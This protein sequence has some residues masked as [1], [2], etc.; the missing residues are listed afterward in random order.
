MALGWGIA[1]L[2]AIT[3]I[4]L[5]VRIF[6]KTAYKIIM[7]IWFILFLGMIVFGIL[8]YSDAK[9]FSQGFSENKSLFLLEAEEEILAGF[10]T[11]KEDSEIV[12]GVEDINSKY[13]DQNFEGILGDEYFKMFV[14]NETAFDDLGIIEMQGFNVTSEEVLEVI[15]AEDVVNAYQ[16]M[17]EDKGYTDDAVDEM[18]TDKIKGLLFGVM[19]SIANKDDP[20]FLF[21][22]YRNGNIRVY[23]ESLIFKLIKNFPEFLMEDVMEKI[24]VQKDGNS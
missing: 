15:K 18:D 11:Y 23:E 6:F 5:I 10:Y 22:N 24:E 8:I 1:I 19:F 12:V 4:M 14:V 7:I 9:D 2:V 21:T 13:Q 16:D 20:T 3:V 17:I